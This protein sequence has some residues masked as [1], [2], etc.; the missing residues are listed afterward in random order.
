[1]SL[2]APIYGNVDSFLDVEKA[3]D[4]DE[5]ESFAILQEVTDKKPEGIGPVLV[6]SLQSFAK[7][8]LL[9]VEAA[10]AVAHVVNATEETRRSAALDPGSLPG[11]SRAEAQELAKVC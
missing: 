2:V 6:S 4:L 7:E 11:M 9:Q 10:R 3:C 5:S 8:K 1:M